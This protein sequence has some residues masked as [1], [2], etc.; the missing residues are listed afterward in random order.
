LV[1]DNSHFFNMPKSGEFLIEVTLSCADAQ[2][3]DAKHAARIRG[4]DNHFN[5]W[6]FFTVINSNTNNG[7]MRWAPRRRG[8]TLRTS[9]A[10]ITSAARRTA[11][12]GSTARGIATFAS[13]GGSRRRWSIIGI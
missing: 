13:A 8:S 11:R 2:A 7:C 9:R 3:K 1:V 4:L 12:P 6:K 5:K 10:T